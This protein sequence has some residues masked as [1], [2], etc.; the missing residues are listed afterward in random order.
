MVWYLLFII[1]LICIFVSTMFV[2]TKLFHFFHKHTNHT[3]VT[4]Y[5]LSL[6]YLPGT[7]LHELSHLFTSIIL[8]VP[9]HGFDLIPR[10]DQND[11][12][13]Y[14]ARLGAV[15]HAQTDPIRGMLIGASPIFF[16][17]AFFYI[18]FE[19][20]FFPHSHILV[21][22]GM[23][24]LFFTVSS[25]MFSSKQ[26]L[27]ESIILIPILGLLGIA[28]VIGFK[29]PLGEILTRLQ[30]IELMRNFN[31]YIAPATGIHCIAALIVRRI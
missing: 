27:K 3:S 14:H 6:I 7:I 9:V 24:Y 28:L 22:I 13:H 4:F 18:V 12:G 2:M 10:I 15:H 17:L 25:S 8:F 19:S 16:G 21:N 30:A 23:L 29:V 5:L 11:N 26:D 20:Q 1:Q 31:T